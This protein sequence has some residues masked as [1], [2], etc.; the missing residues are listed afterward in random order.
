MA[1]III[2]DLL[3]IFPLINHHF[4]QIVTRDFFF[5][6]FLII[7]GSQIDRPCQLAS[8]EIVV[9]FV[10]GRIK[11]F[12]I[13]SNKVGVSLADC[14]VNIFKSVEWKEETTKRRPCC[15]TAAVADC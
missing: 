15:V 14:F 2:S 10:S 5:F 3:T 4:Q 9:V 11:F 12:E 1:A 7:I 13:S 6:F 8:N